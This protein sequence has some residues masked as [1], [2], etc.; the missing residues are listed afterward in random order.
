[1]DHPYHLDSAVCG[2]VTLF[3]SDKCDWACLTACPDFRRCCTCLAGS[4]QGDVLGCSGQTDPTGAVPEGLGAGKGDSQ[5]SMHRVVAADRPTCASHL[6]LTRE[7][8]ALS[9]SCASID[10]CHHE[11]SAKSALSA[12]LSL[13]RAVVSAGNSTLLQKWW[14]FRNTSSSC[15]R[16]RS[17]RFASGSCLQQ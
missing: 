12:A 11:T 2:L 14:L 13:T 7:S 5:A 3:P 9:L 16:L 15:N 8:S 17:Q 10:P 4:R 6:A 1:M